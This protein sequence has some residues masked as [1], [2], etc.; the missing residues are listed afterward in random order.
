MNAF[1][2]VITTFGETEKMTGPSG[3]SCS[4]EC[5]SFSKTR[6]QPFGGRNFEKEGDTI[7]V[8]VHFHITFTTSINL[9]TQ[10]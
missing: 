3:I 1:K 2:V 9:G 8:G 7:K 4:S 10:L 6:G 5:D